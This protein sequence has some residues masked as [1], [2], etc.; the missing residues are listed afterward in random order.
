MLPI[1]S[2]LALH[3]IDMG[4][5]RPRG[6][7]TS[8]SPD[9][10][11]QVVAGND[12]PDISEEHGDDF[13]LLLCHFNWLAIHENIST[14]AWNQIFS[15]EDG[16]IRF[17]RD[18][19]ASDYS[20]YSGDKVFFAHR[21]AD[22]VICSSVENVRGGTVRQYAGQRDDWNFLTEI[23][24]NPANEIEPQHGRNRQFEDNEIEH[25]LLKGAHGVSSV[26]DDD[27][28]IF[29]LLTEKA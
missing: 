11:Y 17:F 3:A 28:I 12:T 25:Q 5:Q 20:I 6:R 27:H 19:C 21:H 1:E 18:V 14:S 7:V 29:A 2:Q 10:R 23:M 4:V 15:D 9:K 8:V 22:P 26:L 24:P 13:E 16:G